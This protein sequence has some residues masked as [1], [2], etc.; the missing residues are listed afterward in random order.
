MNVGC[1]MSL[2]RTL[3]AGSL[4]GM[5]TLK[6]ISTLQRIPR[7]FY[8]AKPSLTEPSWT[9]RRTP[10]SRANAVARNAQSFSRRFSQMNT[11]ECGG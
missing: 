1:W 2:A 3:S 11:D 8:D 7:K 5:P 6:N 10:Y 9:R 4:L